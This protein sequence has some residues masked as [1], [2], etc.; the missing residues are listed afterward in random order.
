MAL[1]YP[2]MTCPLC[3]KPMD[4]DGDLFATLHFLTPDSDLYTYSDAAMHWDC[5]MAWEHQ[6]RFARLYFETKIRWNNEYW[7]VLLKTDDVFVT[8]NPDPY[9]AEVD[10]LLAKSGT[11]YRVAI[12][13]WDDWL[14]SEWMDCGHEF[15]REALGDVLADIRKALPSR[16]ALLEMV[17]KLG[18]PKPV[19]GGGSMEDIMLYLACDKILRRAKAKGIICPACKKF[20]FEY[21]PFPAERGT[22]LVCGQC[23]AKSSPLDF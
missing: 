11:S 15:E 19:A 12:R 2:G 20:G 21:Q 17:N 1:L 13:D 23:G 6:A 8:A 22:H 14:A 10:V 16:L 5:Y 7:C 9:I 18:R 3:E 4:M